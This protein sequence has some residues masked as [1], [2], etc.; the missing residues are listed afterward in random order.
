MANVQFGR[1]ERVIGVKVLR[2]LVRARAAAGFVPAARK[3]RVYA[4]RRKCERGFWGFINALMALIKHIINYTYAK[5]GDFTFIYSKIIPR[6]AFA[7]KK[8][9]FFAL[10]FT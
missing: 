1:E 10:F 9:S 4:G 2:V 7:T 8:L 3:I 5:C 6:K